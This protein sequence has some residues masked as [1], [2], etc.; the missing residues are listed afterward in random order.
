MRLI[1]FIG[2]IINISLA[3]WIQDRFAIV[4]W[5]DPDLGIVK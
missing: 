4:A 1:I 5:W 2:L 3:D